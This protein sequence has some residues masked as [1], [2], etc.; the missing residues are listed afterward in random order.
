MSRDDK[1]PKDYRSAQVLAIAGGHFVHDTYSAFVAPLLPLIIER[2][3]LS[4]MLAG[5]LTLYLQIP[6]LLNRCSR[7]S[8]SMYSNAIQGIPSSSPVS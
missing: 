3:S 2:L 5:S 4:L 7:L 8:P 6:S 1:N